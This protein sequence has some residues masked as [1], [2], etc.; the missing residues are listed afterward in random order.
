VSWAYTA[1]LEST[2]NGNS[3]AATSSVYLC[4]DNLWHVSAYFKRLA[5][6][7]CVGADGIFHATPYLV[8]HRKFVKESPRKAPA[9]RQ[10]QGE[11][12][13]LG[14]YQ[15]VTAPLSEFARDRKRVFCHACVGTFA[16]ALRC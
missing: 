15:P 16:H 11:Q 1:G 9:I 5:T 10:R 14:A 6:G 13:V 3:E 4:V 12:Q 2:P 7:R 8:R